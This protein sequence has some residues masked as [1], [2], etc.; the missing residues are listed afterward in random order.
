MALVIFPYRN[1]FEGIF[2][3][4]RYVAFERCPSLR[5]LSVTLILY[6]MLLILEAPKFHY[7]PDIL[8]NSNMFVLGEWWSEWEYLTDQ[9]PSTD[10]LL[11]TCAMK[12]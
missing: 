6:Q 9:L 11:I 12:F 8:I 7:L 2:Q 1:L 5:V 3:T 4:F 10:V